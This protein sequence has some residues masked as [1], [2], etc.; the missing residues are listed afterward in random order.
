MKVFSNFFS[1]GGWPA[2]LTGFNVPV[3]LIEAK[4]DTSRSLTNKF[5]T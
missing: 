1:D 4:P 5:K 3:E 2:S